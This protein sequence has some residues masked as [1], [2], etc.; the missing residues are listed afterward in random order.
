MNTYVSHGCAIE[1]H[2]IPKKYYYDDPQWNTEF[3][4]VAGHFLRKGLR[5]LE[6]GRVVGRLAYQGLN[7]MQAILSQ[8]SREAD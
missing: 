7:T 3:E 2:L 1:D 5:L 6:I 4:L 8:L